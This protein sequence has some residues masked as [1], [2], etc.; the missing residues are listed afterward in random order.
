MPKIG[1]G[2]TKSVT[3]KVE[4]KTNTKE[5]EEECT[6]FSIY[7]EPEN[8]NNYEKLIPEHIQNSTILGGDMNNADTKM[9][10]QAKVYHFQNIREIIQT[11]NIPKKKSQHPILIFKK[12]IKILIINTIE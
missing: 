9:K 4:I 1:G 5:T 11:I 6:I 8:E 3:V 2:Q 10:L 12:E 7:L